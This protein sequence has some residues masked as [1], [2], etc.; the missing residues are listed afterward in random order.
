MEFTN[1]I[2]V[3]LRVFKLSHSLGPSRQCVAVLFAKNACADN[4]VRAREL[5]AAAKPE[6]APTSTA[7]DSGKPSCPC[8]GGRMIIIG[9]F[10]CGAAT[11]DGRD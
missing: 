11:A 3:Q 4:I 2:L 1:I 8:C 7:A 9:V 10:E 5:L 6:A